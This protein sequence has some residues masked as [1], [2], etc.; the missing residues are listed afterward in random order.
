MVYATI[1]DKTMEETRNI[2][3]RESIISLSFRLF[4]AELLIGLV[5]LLIRVPMLLAINSVA[6]SLWV[7]FYYA[8]FYFIFQIFNIGVLIT[9]ILQWYSRSYVIREKD[10][11]FKTGVFNTEEKIVQ[12]DNVEKIT[13]NQ[14][15]IGRFFNYGTIDIFNPL[16][17]TNVTFSNIPKPKFYAN[18]IQNIVPKVGDN[19][20]KIILR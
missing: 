18:Y 4:I 12:Y 13:V 5:G 9:I 10:F 3:V 7:Y 11:I 20:Q 2:T 1:V 14:S 6:A 15:L 8:I 19:D 16:L 17:R